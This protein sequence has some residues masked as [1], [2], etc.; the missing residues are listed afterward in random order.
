MAN[1]EK[2]IS[3]EK[4]PN[5]L[6]DNPTIGHTKLQESLERNI[7]VTAK[8][9]CDM[10][11]DTRNAATKYLKEISKA[12]A[13]LQLAVGATAGWFAGYFTMK[14]GKSATTMIGCSLLILQI[15]HHKGY[16]KVNWQ[17][18]SNDCAAAA[19][20]TKASLVKKGKNG[21][22]QIQEFAEENVYLSGGFILGIALS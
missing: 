5:I 16:V 15:A 6:L 19:D 7:A 22:E 14:I 3:V 10:S 18:L 21:F 11:Q 1:L 2:H 20:K 9:L 17:P 12:P 4:H 13:P 8:P